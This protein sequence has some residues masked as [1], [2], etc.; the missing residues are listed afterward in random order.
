M[1]VRQRWEA[2]AVNHTTITNATTTTTTNNTTTTT[3]NN[4][5]ASAAKGP[6]LATGNETSGAKNMGGVEGG[7]GG[8]GEEVGRVGCYGENCL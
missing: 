3:N 7:G 2:V 6:G 4:S 1:K 8:C 5:Q